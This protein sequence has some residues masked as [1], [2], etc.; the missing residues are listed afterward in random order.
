MFL[1]KFLFILR[2]IIGSDKLISLNI[3]FSLLFICKNK[4]SIIKKRL[5]N[6]FD[7][8]YYIL[9]MLLSRSRYFHN[10]DL[11]KILLSIK[12]IILSSFKIMYI[13]ISMRVVN[14][15]NVVRHNITIFFRNYSF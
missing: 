3:L 1:S 2:F 8:V 6:K 14:I 12:F 4:L 15:Y 11:E 9:F 7:Q 5:I 13:E 10:W